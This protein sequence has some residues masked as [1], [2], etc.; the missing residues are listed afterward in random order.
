[1]YE[2]GQIR[3]KREAAAQARRLIPHFTRLDDRARVLD[4][5]QELE[6]QAAALEQ[7][8]AT[9]APVTQEMQQKS[10][11]SANEDHKPA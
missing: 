3:A 4:F 5:A 10:G 1:M 6:A 11:P 8:M 2:Q 9:A 7:A